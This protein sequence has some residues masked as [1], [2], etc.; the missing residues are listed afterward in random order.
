MHS[1]KQRL[2]LAAGLGCALLGWGA[3]ARAQGVDEF[4][5][6]GGKGEDSGESEQNAAVELRFGRYVP[7]VDSELSGATPYQ[8]TFGKD[9]RY[10][11]GLEVDWQVLRIPKFGSL[12]PGV[13]LSYTK[14]TAKAF[15]HDSTVRSEQ[16]T[17]L[18]ILPMYLVGVLRV[19][20]LARQTA[21]PL[22]AYVKG[23]L[24]A[25]MWWVGGPDGTA[26]DASGKK[27]KGLSYGL[28]WALGAMLLLDF[29]DQDASRDMDN[30]IGVNNSYFFVEWTNA[31]LGCF[32]GDCMQVGTS[33]WTLGFALEM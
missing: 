6:Y 14:S 1:S 8:T 31:D 9:S 24:G 33:T 21:V 15:Q 2:L 5:A 30:S 26:R 20:V 10:A 23:G 12:G 18:T 16:E 11:L 22:A 17:T 27:G 4:G 29:L 32:G 28:H 25:G 3:P 7:D 13:G 19:D